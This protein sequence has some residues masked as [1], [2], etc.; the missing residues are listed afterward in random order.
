M[1]EDKKNPKAAKI[2]D[3]LIGSLAV[4]AVNNKGDV[5]SIP[6]IN[7]KGQATFN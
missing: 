6:Y 4:S 2:V 5:L 7:V 1:K 3:L